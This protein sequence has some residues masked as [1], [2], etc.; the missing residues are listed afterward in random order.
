MRAGVRD[1]SENFHWALGRPSHKA[2][3]GSLISRN[4]DPMELETGFRAF[5]V[6]PR[7]MSCADCRCSADLK[8]LDQVVRATHISGSYPPMHLFLRGQLS[9]VATI[10]W[11]L[12]TIATILLTSVNVASSATSATEI[13]ASSATR[14]LC[15]KQRSPPF[16][17]PPL[18]S[19]DAGDCEAAENASSQEQCEVD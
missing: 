11:Q 13:V 8:T 18:S 9:T 19:D 17:G 5:P 7:G 15:S 10:L 3:C 16:S 14:P 12:S 2:H 1:I 6:W 4:R